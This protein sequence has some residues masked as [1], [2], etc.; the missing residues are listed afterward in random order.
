[1][2]K[3]VPLVITAVFLA[4]AVGTVLPLAPTAMAQPVNK[5]DAQFSTY[6]IYDSPEDA[7]TNGQVTGRKDWHASIGCGVPLTGLALTLD[8][9][10][11]FDHF[12][13]ENLTTT[14][15]PTYV[16]SFGD[17]P[18]GTH[19]GAYVG[20]GSL[21]S[22]GV[23]PVT[24]T[25]GFDCSRFADKTEF[26]EPG[27]QT[28]TITL[29]PRERTERFEVLINA[30]EN[31][32]VN[33]VITSPTS[34][35]GIELRQEGHQLSISL[36]GLALN[37]TWTTTV[38]IQVTPKVP[39]VEYLPYIAIGWKEP[40][41]SGTASG[42]SVSL[43]VTDMGAWT[44][45]VEG[46][47]EWGWTDE[48]FR[49]VSWRPYSTGIGEDS[50]PAPPEGGEDS[51]PASPVDGN[52]VQLNFST[53]YL[54][55]LYEDTFTNEEVTG[56]VIW[57][58]PNIVNTT[59]ETGEPIRGLKVTLDSDIAFEWVGDENLTKMG[60][61]TY[62]WSWG[63]LVE[64]HKHT[65]WATDVLVGFLYQS[66]IKFTP[67]F[68]VSRSFDKTVFTAP[69]TQT[70][71]VTV[72]PREEWIKGVRI[73]V[74]TD[75]NDLV[76]PVIISHSGG[77]QADVTPDGH[78]SGITI[79]VE[80][81]TP[82]T[83][84]VTIRVTPKVPRVQ[85]EPHVSV[86]PH[87]TVERKRLV[88]ITPAPP[89]PGSMPGGHGTGRRP[90]IGSSFSYTNEAGTW[91]VSAEGNYVWIW[92]AD[93][94]VPEYEVFFFSDGANS[95]PTLTS[96]GVSPLS[97]TPT[98][99]FTFQVTYRDT[100]RATGTFVPSYVRVYIDGSARDM[101]YVSFKGQ[102]YADGAVFSHKTALSAGQHTYYFEA[103]D[104]FFTARFPEDGT[105]SIKVPRW[106]L[107]FTIWIV[108]GVVIIGLVTYFFIRRRRR[109]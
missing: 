71:T 32:Q 58:I 22:P 5:V 35:D 37:T 105:L 61:P 97:G 76:N 95:P 46:S 59:D 34:G 19:R 55:N 6:W 66:P 101:G 103:S 3:L 104:V 17:V 91:T 33:P 4:L 79:P 31:D 67:G 30:G 18:P 9:T 62:E 88:D 2:K 26:S 8:S 21:D 23:A 99:P 78:R 69:D 12:Q 52:M 100:D 64:E 49:Q 51:T 40:L 53:S 89:Q 27:T 63:D 41:A 16:W 43:P 82:V 86:H 29:T 15:P 81:N 24:F 14:G 94:E 70:V 47:Y 20:F 25:P 28:L 106:G 92:A 93:D 98:T 83:I 90:T 102:G 75:E 107:G 48:L 39:E 74:H 11:N 77:E 73:H 54:L 36:A 80:L 44:W 68:D 65:G 38:T 85:Y 87:R 13:K 60:P 109:V 10:L 108:A 42:N 84:T 7:F 50:T 56:Q 45:S 96:G 1:M 57:R 72:T